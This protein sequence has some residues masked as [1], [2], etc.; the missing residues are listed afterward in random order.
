MK[1]TL[2]FETSNAAFDNFEAELRQVFAQAQEKVLAQ[3]E[4]KPGC[5]CDTPE[6]ADK[7]LDTNGNTVGNLVVE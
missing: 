2:T 1:I 5:L 7:I 4:R 3:M 6:A